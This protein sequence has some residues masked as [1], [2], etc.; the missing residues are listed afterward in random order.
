MIIIGNYITTDKETK[1]IIEDGNSAID[2]S[3]YSVQENKNEYILEDDK[4]ITIIQKSSVISL[5]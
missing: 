5:K 2:M 3:N 1:K 4:T